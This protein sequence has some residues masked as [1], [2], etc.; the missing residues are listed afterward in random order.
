MIGS[1]FDRLVV[2]RYSRLE[3]AH[4]LQHLPSIKVSFGMVA[5]QRDSVLE[6]GKH[7]LE[8]PKLFKRRTAAGVCKMI[9]GIEFDRFVIACNSLV[10]SCQLCERQAAAVIRQVQEK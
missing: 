9:D 4:L 6:T 7:L 3:S 10:V 8:P 5:V 2:A 1:E